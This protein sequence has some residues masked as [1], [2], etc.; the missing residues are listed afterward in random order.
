MLKWRE[1]QQSVVRNAIEGN[2]TGLWAQVKE[3]YWCKV[4]NAQAGNMIAEVLKV[5]YLDEGEYL[6]NV[7]L[8][9]AIE[10]RQEGAGMG[11]QGALSFEEAKAECDKM[12]EELGT[13]GPETGNFDFV[14]GLSESGQFEFLGNRPPTLDD[15]AHD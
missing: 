6:S 9:G 1:A 13:E 12:A 8:M 5:D 11:T 15:T 7:T 10:P 4:V 14:I 2:S 3:D